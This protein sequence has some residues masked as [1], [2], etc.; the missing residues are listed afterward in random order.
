M[1]ELGI[2]IALFTLFGAPLASWVIINRKITRL[3]TENAA[4]EKQ[5]ASL[6][7][8]TKAENKRLEKDYKERF[9]VVKNDQDKYEQNMSRTLNSL[10]EKLEDNKNDILLKIEGVTKEITELKIK[11]S[12]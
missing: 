1:E 11:M 12:K 10:F 9:D 8:N 5:F 2:I 3:E 6:E 4:M 7:V